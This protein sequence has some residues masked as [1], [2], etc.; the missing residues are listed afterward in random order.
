[1]KILFL[2]ST[3]PRWRGDLQADFVGEQA[4]AWAEARP[5]DRVFILAPHDAGAADR[6]Q[7]GSIEVRRFRY[8]RSEERQHLAYP[9]I[10][11]NIRRNPWLALQVPIFIVAQYRAARRLV[12][13]E[14]IDLVYAHWVLPQGLTAYFLKKRCGIHYVLQNHSSDLRVFER[15]GPLGRLVARTVLG[16]SKHLFCVNSFQRD[17]ALSLFPKGEAHTMGRRITVLP[18]GVKQLRSQHVSAGV[19]HFDFGTIS[20]LSVKKGLDFLIEAVALLAGRGRD[21]RVAIAGDGEER[22]SLEA[23]GRSLGISFPGF[24][25]DDEKAQFFDLTNAFVFPAKAS[26]GD[27]EGLPVALLEALV[28]G[29]PVIAG[30]DTNIAMLPEWNTIRECVTFVENP[31][32]IVELANAME[33]ILD[34]PPKEKDRRL[35]ILQEV[36]R[37]YYWDRLIKEYLLAIGID[38]KP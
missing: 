13:E 31:A 34:L 9:A 4:E 27:V 20:R 22:A 37:R 8:A 2:T 10:L 29:K 24:L 30:G 1:M 11:P 28:A 36:T 17:H 38:S 33:H 3:Y 26:G 7:R 21:I 19:A 15:F 23:A 18:M 12:R 32:N 5:Q 25:R 6:E 35:R 16:D 14:K